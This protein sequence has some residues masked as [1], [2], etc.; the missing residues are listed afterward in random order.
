MPAT[1]SAKAKVINATWKASLPFNIVVTDDSERSWEEK[2]LSP[3][4]E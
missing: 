3:D 1:T 2:D 4:I